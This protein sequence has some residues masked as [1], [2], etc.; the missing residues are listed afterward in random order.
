MLCVGRV[1][2]P[3]TLWEAQPPLGDGGIVGT[4]P[5]W[6]GVVALGLAH[7]K[8]VGV[9]SQGVVKQLHWARTAHQGDA[10][11]PDGFAPISGVSLAVKWTLAADEGDR[12][13][14]AREVMNLRA[15]AGQ[16]HVVRLWS[17]FWHA[18]TRQGMLIME[19]GTISMQH[20]TAHHGRLDSPMSRRFVRELC[21]GVASLHALCIL[22]R[23]LAP[24]NLVLFLGGAGFVLK[25]CDFGSSIR[26]RSAVAHR[27]RGHPSLAPLLEG[28]CTLPYAAPEALKRREAVGPGADVWSVAIVAWEWLSD[29]PNTRLGPC[30]ALGPS[31]VLSDQVAS[32]ALK[33]LM[34]I[35][36]ASLAHSGGDEARQNLLDVV[37]ELQLPERRPTASAL[38]LRFCDHRVSTNAPDTTTPVAHPAAESRCGG[39]PISG[40]SAPA[41]EPAAA[42]VRRRI[43]GRSSVKLEATNTR[44]SWR[45]PAA[46]HEVKAGKDIL[47]ELVPCDVESFLASY[48]ALGP[49]DW[50]LEYVV[51]MAQYPLAVEKFTE[52]ATQL[53]GRL[54]PGLPEYTAV[55]LRDVLHK[56]TMYA[57][58]LNSDSRMQAH[59]QTLDRT[60]GYCKGLARVM[61][62]LCVLRKMD[63]DDEIQREGHRLKVDGE[64]RWQWYPIKTVRLG[65]AQPP[66]KYQ[67]LYECSVLEQLLAACRAAPTAPGGADVEILRK[68]VRAQAD[69]TQHMDAFVRFLGTWPAELHVRPPKGSSSSQAYLHKAFVRKHLF[70]LVRPPDVRQI[71][72]LDLPLSAWRSWLPDVDGV[73]DSIPDSTT[74]REL[75][76]EMGGVPAELVA[77]FGCLFLRVHA[78]PLKARQ[79]W[80]NPVHKPAMLEAVAAYKLDYGIAPLPEH[81]TNMVM[82]GSAPSPHHE[83][84]CEC[85]GNCDTRCPARKLGQRCPHIAVVN[86]G[87]QPKQIKAAGYR[88]LRPLCQH[89]VCAHAGCAVGKRP[90]PDQNLH[91]PYC[92]KHQRDHS[93]S[94][95][96]TWRSCTA[97]E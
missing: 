81:L 97:E 44:A 46:L 31:G 7:G 28:R 36:F 76:V 92:S 41:S 89:C 75:E 93:Q 38:Q 86:L 90:R 35:D 3:V 66:I 54:G 33:I 43:R 10:S 80:L 69:L 57:A 96:V 85:T 88:G 22:H 84:T 13:D 27:S 23:D 37:C 91:G 14:F 51:A 83:R 63:E 8:E 39:A 56:T 5:Q 72:W 42:P 45:V 26:I 55:D 61:E 11:W 79:L 16:P 94:L 82:Q 18:Q 12:T 50:A 19:L 4:L 48:T 21:S 60:A 20:F 67:L 2:K 53:P 15:L 73:T 58:T 68:P 32:A 9:G 34:A 74:A 71:A 30:I 29:C 78:M 17:V 87:V 64:S 95:R 40:V 49:H 6:P 65:K 52:F 59:M 24:K 25:I 47:D 1:P 62:K 77:C 70:A